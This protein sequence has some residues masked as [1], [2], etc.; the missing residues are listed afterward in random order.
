MLGLDKG[1]LALLIPIVA[2]AGGILGW[3]VSEL[4][5]NSRKKAQTRE[6]EATRREVAAYVAEGSMTPEDGERLL[7]AGDDIADDKQA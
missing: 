7:R 4:S 3:I 5:N 6:R 1:T 2:V